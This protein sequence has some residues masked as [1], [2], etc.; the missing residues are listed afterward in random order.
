MIDD[1]RTESK[2]VYVRLNDC[3]GSMHRHSE[4]ELVY[5]LRG[6]GVLLVGNTS[7][8]LNVGDFRIINYGNM[9]RITSEDDDFLC[10]SLFLDVELFSRYIPGIDSEFFECEPSKTI[11]GETENYYANLLAA[12]WSIVRDAASSGAEKDAAHRQHLQKRI[13][14]NSIT[15]LLDLR[16]WFTLMYKQMSLTEEDSERIWKVVDY[17]YDNYSRKLPIVE[18][19]SLIH[20]TPNYL[21]HYIKK[22]S[23]MSY[24]HLL[25]FIRSEIALEQLITTRKS[26]SRISSECGFSEPKYFNKYFDLFYHISPKKYRE[27]Y[28][29]SA[30][31]QQNVLS[32]SVT[33]EYPNDEAA[34]L[35][36]DAIVSATSGTEFWLSES[37]SV[38][39]TAD[40]EKAKGSASAP[41][42]SF[43]F[44]ACTSA[45]ILTPE[46]YLQQ[47]IMQ[48]DPEVICCNKSWCVCGRPDSFQILIVNNAEEETTVEISLF[49]Q[50]GGFSI[51]EFF[52]D[53]S[54]YKLAVDDYDHAASKMPVNRHQL[55]SMIYAPQVKY[56]TEHYYG[57]VFK[58]R[59]LS[60]KS[61][62]L[63]VYQ[64]I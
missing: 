60:A 45:G 36:K 64:A 5:A 9:H 51:A 2:Y 7:H 56:S 28:G 40:F 47:F 41:S 34:S 17:I 38:K 20:V 63:Y 31:D 24:Q 26:I 42:F 6:S 57:D 44:P 37:A 43:G 3:P 21:S 15:L 50:N 46:Y 30:P 11:G 13:T 59:F 4:L 54:D 25:N 8:S 62:V 49:D 39:V 61:A 35:M 12:Y 16:N 27:Q 33:F 14:D 32:G 1:Y 29:Y 48:M 55:F 52:V 22:I 53:G 23:G 19:A 10:V 58:S 18:I